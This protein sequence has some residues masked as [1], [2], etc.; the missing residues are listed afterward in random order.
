MR[1]FRKAVHFLRIPCKDEIP[2]L[3][4][5]PLLTTGTAPALPVPFPLVEM[6]PPALCFTPHLMTTVC[7]EVQL[8][9]PDSV[10]PDSS[11]LCLVFPLNASQITPSWFL[12]HLEENTAFPLCCMDSNSPTQSVPSKGLGSIS[13]L[14]PL[15]F[16]LQTMTSLKETS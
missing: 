4:Q 15:N 2:L 7:H 8:S 5:I 13:V 1:I 3:S 6:P 11:T 16:C 12:L 14:W 10:F 9:W